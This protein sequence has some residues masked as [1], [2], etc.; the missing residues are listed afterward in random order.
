MVSYL[1]AWRRREIG[2]RV[3]MG[4]RP[5]Q[6]RQLVLSESVILAGFGIFIGL[7]GAA[8][9]T[10]YLESMLFGI[11][12]RDVATFVVMPLFVGVLTIIASLLPANRAAHIDPL[13][14]LREE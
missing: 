9:V 4:A 5:G 8:L 6:V 14:V 10:G 11:R 3:A 12:P 7:I 2:V 1:V 13:L